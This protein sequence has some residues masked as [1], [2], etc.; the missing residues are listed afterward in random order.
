M[1]SKV[2][3][4]YP[5]FFSQKQISSEDV[6]KESSS[7][8]DHYWSKNLY[9][10]TCGF[11]NIVAQRFHLAKSVIIVWVCKSSFLLFDW[12]YA[13]GNTQ[14][15]FLLKIR[16]CVFVTKCCA[17]KIVVLFCVSK[18]ATSSWYTSVSWKF[19]E[20]NSIHKHFHNDTGVLNSN[21]VLC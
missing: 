13:V 2:V 19:R 14:E 11:G 18:H 7:N 1:S 17:P 16:M 8:I 6:P 21:I 3:H 4:F 12:K 10:T 5:Y 20:A 9:V 15:L